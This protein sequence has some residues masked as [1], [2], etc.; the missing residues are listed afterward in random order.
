MSG[1][2]L[3][4]PVPQ[5]R[6]RTWP[7]KHERNQ[8]FRAGLSVIW[9]LAII[10]VV[11][12]VNALSAY[13]LTVF[14]I[15]PRDVDTLWGI[16]SAPFI[17]VNYAHLLANTSAGAVI[18]FLLAISGRRELWFSSTVIVLVGGLGVWIFG[19]PYTVVVGASGLIYGWLTYLVARGFFTRQPLQIALGVIV[20]ITYAGM[21][22][23]ILPGDQGVSWQGH[24]F[25]ALGGVIAAWL[26]VIMGKLT[27]AANAKARKGIA[28]AR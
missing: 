16:L 2:N 8:F 5:R 6:T 13:R 24:L 10:W 26:S 1:N 9:F 25:G 14:G 15:H 3:G 17:H 21:I 4:R 20:G 7:V 12:I 19:N 11:H 27:P 18:L 22:W 28:S 23:G